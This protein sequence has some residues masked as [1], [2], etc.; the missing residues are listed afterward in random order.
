MK[1]LPWKDP[2]GQLP[3]CGSVLIF[4]FFFFEPVDD[5]G[6]TAPAVALS[7]PECQW[8]QGEVRKTAWQWQEEVISVMGYSASPQKRYVDV[9][10]LGTSEGDSF[11]NGVTAGIIS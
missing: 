5:D 2:Q 4:F 9:L 7:S 11:G 10:I 1:F 8:L 3:A 6:L